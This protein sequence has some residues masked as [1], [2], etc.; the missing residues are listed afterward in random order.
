MTDESLSHV[1]DDGKLRMVDVSEKASTRRTALASCRVRT[2]LR[3]SDL[4]IHANGVDVLQAARLAGVN[5][6]KLTSQIIPLCHPL[7]LD[8]IDVTVGDD[9]HG[10]TVLARVVVVGRTGVE[11]EAL[12]ACAFAALTL[13]NALRARDRA[14][15]LEDLLVR[16][17][18]GGK[19]ADWGRDLDAP[20]PG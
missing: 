7:A 20:R 9:E 3:V 15:R 12:A 18:T 17:K 19:S 2:T 5:A 6:A 13:L 14:A 11:M 8:D 1:D 10:L 16:E 4:G